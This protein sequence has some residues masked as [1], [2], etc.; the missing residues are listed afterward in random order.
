MFY[1]SP[2]LDDSLHNI[3][4]R[5]AQVGGD[6]NYSFLMITVYTHSG[7]N[8][9]GDMRMVSGGEN[10]SNGSS[11]TAAIVGGVLGSVIFFLLAI[12][13][14]FYLWRNRLMAQMS[15]RGPERSVPTM[16]YA[17][18]VSNGGK[19]HDFAKYTDLTSDP[20]RK[21]AVYARACPCN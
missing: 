19:Y 18:P 1:Q 10:H 8:N 5:M 11:K 20:L 6:R 12:L 13:L 17:R 7:S 16:R 21:G 3:T 4:I 2:L 14:A 15:K 9:T